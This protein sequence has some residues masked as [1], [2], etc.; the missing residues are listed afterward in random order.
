MQRAIVTSC[1]STKLPDS[2]APIGISRGTPRNRSGFRRYTPLQP[3]P[4]FSTASLEEFTKLYGD[5]LNALD[6]E[7]VVRD[8]HEIAGD[9]MPTLLCWEPAEPGPKWCHRGLVAA[10]LYD[11]LG[12]EVF[13][14][15]QEHEGCGHAHPKLHPDVRVTGSQR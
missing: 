2:H 5:I 6:P 10:W 3:G 9:R 1:W 15:G 8:L 12:L 7:K 14:F 11:K 4:W 13:E